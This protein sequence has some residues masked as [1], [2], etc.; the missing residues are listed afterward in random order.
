M[1][2]SDPDLLLGGGGQQPGAAPLSLKSVLRRA[3]RR[4]MITETDEEEEWAE[5]TPRGAEEEEEGG[6]CAAGD[7]HSGVEHVACGAPADGAVPAGAVAPRPSG[8]VSSGSAVELQEAAPATVD[9]P[10]PAGS[11][12]PPAQPQR[13][14]SRPAS[15]P[16]AV[17]AF[18]S[19]FED[20]EAPSFALLDTSPP[21][22]EA[23][24]PPPVD[25][26]QPFT[27]LSL[28]TR[29]CQQTG[30][31]SCAADPPART[32]QAEMAGWL[33]AHARGGRHR[34]G[35]PLESAKAPRAPRSQGFSNKQT[36]IDPLIGCAAAW[37]LARRAAGPAD[38][39]VTATLYALCKTFLGKLLFLDPATQKPQVRR[40][41][42]ARLAPR[43]GLLAPQEPGPLPAW[44]RVAPDGRRPST[45]RH[46]ALA[47]CVL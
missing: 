20:G 42:R 22:G 33:A 46:P 7:K 30:Q 27:Y 10:P 6:P 38:F 37:P 8:S 29:R 13:H 5:E 9:K 47:P 15:L 35:G 3:K 41:W 45:L 4:R 23:A 21:A 25:L 26:G 16:P 14:P 19:D 2:G 11:A 40:A 24:R 18:S 34:A 1:G 17:P 32:A 31:R 36:K 43:G 44:R 39:P 12:P 28:L